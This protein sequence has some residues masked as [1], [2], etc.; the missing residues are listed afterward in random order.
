ME[1]MKLK[2]FSLLFSIVGILLLYFLS[3]L[4]QPP[5]IEIFEIPDYD[6][7]QVI[8]RGIVKDYSNSRFGS[9][10][11]TIGENNHS[12]IVFL[13]GNFDV[14]YGDKIQAR[15][16]VQKYKDGW[17]IIVN[18]RQFVEILAKWNNTSFPLWQLANNPMKYLNL[19]VKV[20]G[21]IESISNADF[22]LVDI[23][24]KNSLMVSYSNLKNISIYPGQLVNVSGK[25]IF[26]EINFRY[27][28]KIFD[29][30]HGI[31]QINKE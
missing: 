3:K 13:E 19:N 15:G 24:N 11:I 30:K 23:E 10:Q 16:E 31:S 7:K 22:Y 12:V 29:E 21:Y 25:F 18:D 17:E 1:K 9:K 20:K 27:Q 28:L 2:Y 26:D 6:G 8:T 4:T 14:E 5:L